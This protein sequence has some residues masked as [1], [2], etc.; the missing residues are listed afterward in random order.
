MREA[1][2]QIQMPEIP[3]R[4]HRE[5]ST[6]CHLEA[7]MANAVDGPHVLLY[8]VEAIDCQQLEGFHWQTVEANMTGRSA[9]P[10]T[11][12]SLKTKKGLLL[13]AF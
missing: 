2:A 9:E 13:P 5:A 3:A 8:S 4:A 7:D 11:S 1:A 6:S 12:F 10:G